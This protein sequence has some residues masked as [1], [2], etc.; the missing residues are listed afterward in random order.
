[1]EKAFD[2][3]PNEKLLY[4]L[5]Y[6]GFRNPGGAALDILLPRWL[7]TPRLKKI[8]RLKPFDISDHHFSN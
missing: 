2:R 3:V 8:F 1:M 5:E 4:E 7:R 6:L